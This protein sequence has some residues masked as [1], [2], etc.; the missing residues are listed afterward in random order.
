MITPDGK[1]LL[2]EG[3]WV[4]AGQIM[5]ALGTLA[6]LRLMTA[7]LPPK[8]FGE[9]VLLS[10]IVLLANG[11]AASPL[12][13]GVLRFYPEAARANNI[14][15]LRT[16]TQSFL[17]RFTLLT[18]AL[19]LGGFLLYG[20][21]A[22][23]NGWLGILIVAL[24][25]VDV[26]RQ[27]ELTMLN[28][29]RRQQATAVWIA[30]D[31]WARPTAAWVMIATAGA[32][33]LATMVGYVMASGLLLAWLVCWR[34]RENKGDRTPARPGLGIPGPT[35]G[36]EAR[37]PGIRFP[38][39]DEALSKAL[40]RY[41]MPLMPLGIIGWLTG[42]AD[43]YLLGAM[44]GV[45]EAGLYAALYGIVSRP[46]LMAG[47]ILEAWVRPIYYETVVAREVEREKR[48][49]Q[50]WLSAIACA[51]LAGVGVFSLWHAEIAGI[52]LAEPYRA[53]AG[54]MPWIASGY[55]LL[56]LAQV[57][58]R[59][60]YA[61]RNTKAVLFSETFGCVVALATTL[62]AVNRFG[63]AGAAFTVPV[64]F[65]AQLALTMI[66][67]RR[68]EGRRLNVALAGGRSSA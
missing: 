4:M 36:L 51:A 54:L 2:G 50:M 23:V 8:V 1:Q 47:G 20:A 66:L 49:L 22:P 21:T 13:Q 10:G 31:A 40:M 28:A 34:R 9:V 17:M 44:I 52:L 14:G 68:V 12:M 41:S 24:L 29:A 45:Q 16:V 42:Q 7:L 25:I 62:Y 43:R 46:F 57:Y 58:G 60:C 35:D 39:S 56:L 18:S 48:V 65:S 15:G 55:G 27:L 26:G 61:H 19:C 67:A 37:R 5:S 32:T 59:V 63:L 30:L 33:A 3:A 11:L 6:G 38:E 64:Y 53:N